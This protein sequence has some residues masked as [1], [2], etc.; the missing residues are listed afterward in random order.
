MTVGAALLGALCVVL[1][2]VVGLVAAWNLVRS[3]I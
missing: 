3:V 2:P 1:V